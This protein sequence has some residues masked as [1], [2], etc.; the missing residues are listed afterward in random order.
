MT[1]LTFRLKDG[2]IYDF[3]INADVEK[4]RDR[5]KGAWDLKDDKFML[6]LDQDRVIFLNREDVSF[7]MFE[8]LN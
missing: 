6:V 4:I 2:S 1:K 7:I 8:S 3:D 5:I